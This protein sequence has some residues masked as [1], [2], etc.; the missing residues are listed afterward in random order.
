MSAPLG[1]VPIFIPSVKMVKRGTKAT[2]KFAASGQLT[3]K[4]QARRK[5]QQIQRKISKNKGARSKGRERPADD[6]EDEREGAK[7]IKSLKKRY[8]FLITQWMIF[9]IL[10]IALKA[11]Q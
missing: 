4:I 7:E 3:K 5:H 9:F 8:V 2:R 6:G 1:P 11:C 10:D